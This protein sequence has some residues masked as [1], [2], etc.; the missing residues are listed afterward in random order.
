VSRPPKASPL[1]RRRS[2]YRVY[3]RDVATQVGLGLDTS[4]YGAVRADF[5]RD[6]W[7]DLFIGRHSNPGLLV[8]NQ[9]GQFVRALGVDIRRQ[10]RHGC[11]AGD[12][13]GDG[14]MDLFCA[15]GSLHGAGLKTDELWIQ[16]P[17]GTFQDRAVQMRAADPVGRGRLSIF[18]DLDHDKHADLFIADRPDRTDGL[19]S[20]HRVLANPSGSHYEPRSV[21][22]F[23]AASGADCLRAADLDRDGWQDIVLCERAISRPDGMGIRVLRN[24]KGRLV[25]VTRRVGIPVANVVDAVVAD[26]DGDHVPDIVQVTPWELRIWIRRGSHYVPGYH[27]ALTSAVAVAA[28]DVNGDGAPDLYIAQGTADKQVPDLMLVNGGGGWHF[29]SMPIPQAR[30]GSAE[31]VIATDHDRNGLTDFVVLNG[32]GSQRDGPIQLIAFYPAGATRSAHG[33]QH[34]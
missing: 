12:A 23:D 24:V 5:D 20:R 28:G 27:H 33:G 10:D 34:R 21:V 32:R 4:T 15:L 8:L 16:Q 31:S 30:T 7:P 26:M 25:D 3:A 6:G 17:D 19:P 22:G 9:G 29:R 1:P 18:F 11:T 13:N 14:R 2:G